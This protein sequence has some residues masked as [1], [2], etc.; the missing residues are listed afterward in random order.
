MKNVLVSLILISG[1]I[2]FGSCKKD[3]SNDPKKSKVQLIV[4]SSKTTPTRNVSAEFILES[5][6]VNIA[7]I[8]FG[9]DEDALGLPEN[10]V[11]SI[12]DAQELNGPFLIDLFSTK[13]MAGL[14][15]GAT[16]IPNATYEEVEF[17]LDR[18]LDNTNPEMY[19]NSVFATGT[20]NGLPVKFWSRD[21]IEIEID[22]PDST[23]FKLNGADFNLYLDFSID[24]AK[25]ALSKLDFSSAVDGNKNGIIEIGPNDTDGN[26]KLAHYL[27]EAI[28]DL[29]ELDRE[30][31]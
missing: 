11:D 4:K 27:S 30:N 10:V 23:N 28:E 19:G 17:E 16:L 7:E 8:E 21:E 25:I 3:D 5:M 9:I 12:V 15:L 6:K 26:N 2:Y 1:L 13:A 18:C 20:L 24:K 22:F 31:D 29:F 14:N